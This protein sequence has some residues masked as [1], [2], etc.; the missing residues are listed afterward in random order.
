MSSKVVRV[1]AASVLTAAAVLASA[2]RAADEKPGSVYVQCDGRP[3]VQS[4]GKTSAQ[5]LG[6]MLTAG[7]VG[8]VVGGPEAPDAGKLLEGEKGAAACEAALGLNKNEARGVQL[9]LAK[10]IHE[11][12]TA[13][14]AAAIGDTTT[15]S[16]VA[17]T[18]Q[19]EATYQHG[20][21]LGAMEIEAA[22]L[23][24]SGKAAEAEALVLKMANSVP[25]DLITALQAQTYVGL[26]P[27]MTPAK[28]AFYE[29][30]SKLYPPALIR[31]SVA[32]EWAG[33]FA[34][35]AQHVA[36][37][38][39]V[40]H[41]YQ[42]DPDKPASS[43]LL[44]RQS[45]ATLLAGDLAASNVLADRAKASIDKELHDGTSSQVVTE[46]QELIDFQAVGRQLAEGHAAEARAIFAG[47]SRWFAP[48]PPA[49]AEMATRLR[50][51]ASP[52]QLTGALAVDPAKVRADGMAQVLD[53][54]SS[55]KPIGAS[56]FKA[57]RV[58]NSDPF[59]GLDRQ[60]WRTEKSSL[61]IPRRPNSKYV[62]EGLMLNFYRDGA[63]AGQAL[64]LHAALRAKAQG[65]AGFVVG[66]NRTNIRLVVVRYGD[67][68]T[69]DY[70]K[71]ATFV[72]QQVIDDLSPVLPDPSAKH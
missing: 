15:L 54:V 72:A 31:R 61:L 3:E 51:G 60:V 49:V 46:A 43:L 9:K 21:A 30:V 11:I 48:S 17:P 69:P 16:S 7:I 28:R 42:D 56:L 18:L 23:A 37:Y 32:E 67:P 22:A 2:A 27:E 65:K 58:Q 45:V 64:L 68:G 24:R 62:G 38:I 34:A 13:Q 53:A 5:L 20:L 14:Y 8:G 55:I 6:I 39:A 12:E 66:P 47:R 59:G 4:V 57:V 36:D 50:A 25:Y 41:G 44:A 1:A 33:D 63:A 70:P 10:A 35:S 29:Q 40:I 52:A 71:A 19:N 26:T